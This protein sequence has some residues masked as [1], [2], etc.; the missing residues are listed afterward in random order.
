MK[1][2]PAITDGP[3]APPVG[4]PPTRWS[5]VKRATHGG[6]PLETWIG[7]YWFPLYAWARRRGW[8]PEDAADEVQVFVERVARFQLLDRANPTRGRL[9]SWLLKAFSNHLANVHRHQ[10]RLKRGGTAAHV[11]IDWQNAENVYLEEHGHVLDSDKVFA[12]AWALTVIE[13]AMETLAVHYRKSGRERLFHVLL[14]SL[15]AP[16]SEESYANAAAELAMTGP[17]MRQ[18]ATRFRQRYR[19]ILLDV[20]ARRLGITN[21]A[22]LFEELRDMLAG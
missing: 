11:Q 12:R 7:L 13:E 10:Q 15:E 3:E 20:A 21:E 22:R 18:A 17:A 19:Q 1:R 4:F 6:H 9:R 5:L 8:Q 14:P 2:V 16:F